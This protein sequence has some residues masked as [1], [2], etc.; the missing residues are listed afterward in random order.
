M[1]ELELRSS[2]D[3]VFDR[4]V[5]T[6][7][8]LHR[9]PETAF[10]E[11]ETTQLIKDRLTELGLRPRPGAGATGAVFM[12][13]GGRA[14]TTVL[15][16]ADIDALPITEGTG[17]A[18][19]SDVDGVMHACGHDAHTAALLGVAEVMASRAEHLP[20]RYLFVFQPAEEQVSG[21]RAMLD[22]GLLT[23]T[24]VDAAVGWH[25]TAP[26]PAGLLKVRA[27]VAMSDGQGVGISFTGVGG[28]GARG[29]PNVLLSVAKVLGSM[30]MVVAGMEYDGAACICSPGVVRGG[31]ARN[32]VPASAVIEGSLRTFTSEQKAEALDRLRLLVA[33]AAAEAGVEGELELSVHAPP[34]RNDPAVT[35]VVADTA[36]RCLGPERVVSGPPLAPSDDMSEILSRVPGCYFHVGGGRADGQSGDH[37]SP[38]FDV[39]EEAMRTAAIVLTEAAV[40]LADR[41]NRPQ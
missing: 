21:A 41:P 8:V 5:D 1:A 32:V 33:E 34:V 23:E 30:G 24:P 25:V 31:T 2:I 37:H 4:V 13:E 26:L 16:R 10:A 29:G 39:D 22:A 18:F 36:R 7:R 15:M 11:H 3:A 28:H 38:R 40:A 6:R 27:G 35:E 9:R 14:G 20:G 17:L 12:L 19:S